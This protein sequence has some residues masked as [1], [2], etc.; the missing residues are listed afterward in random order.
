MAPSFTFPILDFTGTDSFTYEVCDES[1]NCTTAVV[2]I[3]VTPI[4]D[5]DPVAVDD[6]FRGP[7]GEEII[8][9]V[10]LNDFDPEGSPLTVTET[11]VVPPTHGTLT[12]ET[13]GNFTYVPDI[14][15][16]GPTVSLTKCVTSPATAQQPL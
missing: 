16:Q 15:S 7:E 14:D 5:D 2:T 11:P 10:L 4:P 1:G 13:D 3:E 9:T 8:G 12:L 6:L